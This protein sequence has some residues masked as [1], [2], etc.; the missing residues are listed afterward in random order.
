[1]I[2]SLLTSMP[3]MVCAVC[4][5]F[6]VLKCLEERIV[7]LR[8]LVAFMV[9]ATVLYGCH[10]LFFNHVVRGGWM[11][12]VVYSL[13]NL[14]VYPLFFV[15]LCRQALGA[16]PHRW[17]LRPL[18]LLLPSVFLPA[19][20]AGVYVAMG[21]EQ[22]NDFV[23]QCLYGNQWTGFEG[24]MQ[25]QVWLH[26]TA[27]VL[28]ALQIVGVVLVGG[29][30]IREH[31]R[32]VH[33]NYADTEG[34]TLGTLHTLLIVMMVTSVAS[35]TVNIIGRH[36]FDGGGLL[37]LAVPSVLFSA[38]LFVVAYVG[39][40]QTV[41]ITAVADD[42]EPA[43][44]ESQPAECFLVPAE[45]EGEVTVPM[46]DEENQGEAGSQTQAPMRQHA[47]KTGELKEVIVRMLQSE[48][49]YLKHDL[50]I[51]D[52]VQR[53]HTNRNYIQQAL[54]T[55]MGCTFSELV[56][57]MR[58]EHAVELMRRHQAMPASEVAEKSGYQSLASFYRNF[59]LIMGCAPKDFKKI[60]NK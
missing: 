1:M 41:P 34:R 2:T 57:R 31:D 38:L 52:L 35:F 24:L 5:L 29:K 58:I 18:L 50:R 15:Y 51:A 43:L 12:D 30:M 37:L 26:M 17:M 7:P 23:L 14:L 21:N 28:F 54:N 6:V 33:D 59:K 36:Y 53:L 8:W 3:M 49:M 16:S 11:I 46:D 27:K 55:E 40:K 45:D 20:M 4:T 9:S 22:S 13:C 47:L 42:V 56:N 10:F 48:Q 32:Y 19:L 44:T 60:S 25:A 39:F